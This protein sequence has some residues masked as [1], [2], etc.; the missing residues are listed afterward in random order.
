MSKSNLIISPT[1]PSLFVIDTFTG[2]VIDLRKTTKIDD[3]SIINIF[4][5]FKGSNLIENNSDST[6]TRNHSRRIY[7]DDYPVSVL[8]GWRMQ[9]VVDPNHFLLGYMFDQ[10]SNIYVYIYTY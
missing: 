2:F 9:F 6:L 4:E 10:T 3:L 1:F 8:V 7:S 5:G